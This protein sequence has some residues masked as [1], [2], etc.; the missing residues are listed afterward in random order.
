MNKLPL[1]EFSG[2]TTKWQH[3]VPRRNLL[4]SRP[5]ELPKPNQNMTISTE[6]LSAR[7]RVH[8][9]WLLGSPEILSW[10]HIPRWTR[11]KLPNIS[12]L[13]NAFLKSLRPSLPAWALI[14]NRPQNSRFYESLRIALKWLSYRPKPAP[15]TFSINPFRALDLGMVAARP[16]TP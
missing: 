12:I 10:N 7:Q 15:H 9:L 5:L 3:G 2:V 16:L 11:P 1:G 14:S 6:F 13:G 8:H 4:Q